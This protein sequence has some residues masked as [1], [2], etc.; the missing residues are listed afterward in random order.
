MD[1]LYNE[2]E[3]VLWIGISLVILWRSRRLPV[4]QVRIARVAALAFFLFGISDAVEVRTGAWW[5][6]WWLFAWKAACVG[7]FAVCWWKYRRA[8]RVAGGPSAPAPRSE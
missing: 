2:F 4:A 7:A 1:K 8:Q 3:V 6:P 5:T